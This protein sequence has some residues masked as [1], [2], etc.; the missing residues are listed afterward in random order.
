MWCNAWKPLSGEGRQ[1]SGE[2]FVRHLPA[3][4]VSE[5][6]ALLRPSQ[7]SEYRSDLY[8]GEETDEV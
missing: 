4:L 1:S 5:L 8:M 3:G 2:L 6:S 7:L